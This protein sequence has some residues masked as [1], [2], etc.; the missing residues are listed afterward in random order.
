MDFIRKDLT[1]KAGMISMIRKIDGV[2]LF[3]QDL[4]ACMVFYRDVLGL[5]IT[6]ND[7][8]SFAFRLEEQDFVLLERTAAV[9]MI[10]EKALAFHNQTSHRVLL[11]VG[12][13]DVNSTYQALTAK[14]LTFIQSPVDQ[15]WGRRTAYFADPE[16]NLWELWQFI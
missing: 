10:G 13:E 8:V 5:P 6:F 11:C 16:G 2:V 4:N 7:E 3:V 1:S 9:P 14:G 12:V 15:A